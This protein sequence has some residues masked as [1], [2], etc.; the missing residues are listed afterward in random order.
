MSWTIEFPAGFNPDTC[1]DNDEVYK[2]YS[3]LQRAINSLA[4]KGVILL[5]A[6]SDKGLNESSRTA[7]VYPG[8]FGY[9]SRDIL[10]I[11]SGGSETKLPYTPVHFLFPGQDV[12]LEPDLGGKA[13]GSSVATAIASGMAAN[14]ICMVDLVNQDKNRRLG[15]QVVSRDKITTKMIAKAFTGLDGS[16]TMMLGV[17]DFHE[18]EMQA[19]T[20]E[21]GGIADKDGR[22]SYEGLTSFKNLL[23]RIMPVNG[24]MMVPV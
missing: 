19:S 18:I 22:L 24:R 23:Q 6:T 13:S 12:P 4:M 3:R 14:I 20:W 10:T 8:E 9:R 17:Y 16:P 1:G 5:C 7:P 15:G 11:G 2:L 21:M